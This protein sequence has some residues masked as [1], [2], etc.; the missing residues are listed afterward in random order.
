MTALPSR[1]RLAWAALRWP[2]P[3]RYGAAIALVALTAAIV[4]LFA[5][6]RGIFA[7]IPLENPGTVFVASVTLAAVAFGAG[8]G[9]AA[10]AAS[11]IAIR[12]FFWSA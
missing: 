8:A 4:S 2:P 5:S 6:D 9:I 7:H 3:A 1:S 10:V 12:L 11:A